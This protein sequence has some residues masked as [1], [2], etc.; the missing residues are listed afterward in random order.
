LAAIADLV[1]IKTAERKSGF[2]G[3]PLENAIGETI[4][5]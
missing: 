5:V 2:L 4:G 1:S 3:A